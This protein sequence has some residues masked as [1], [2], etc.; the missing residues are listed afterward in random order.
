MCDM[1]FD[2]AVDLFEEF[3]SDEPMMSEKPSRRTNKQTRKLARSRKETK[4]F[5]LLTTCCGYRSRSKY[6]GAR[7]INPYE[8]GRMKSLLGS[9]IYVKGHQSGSRKAY[10]RYANKKIRA[11]MRQSELSL[12]NG[13]SRRVFDLAW[14]LD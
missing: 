1:I 6:F 11:A 14:I 13:V 2:D 5:N 8:V 3:F 9:G 7:E 10:K 12:D 4:L